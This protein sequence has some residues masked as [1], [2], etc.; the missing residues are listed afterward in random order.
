VDQP[1]TC[2][3]GLAEHSAVPAKFAELIDAL[4]E[5]LEL[6]T[7]SLDW[8]SPNTQGELVVYRKLAKEYREIANQLASTASYMSGCRDLP[9][10][11]HNQKALSDPSIIRAF[12][13]FTRT[14]EE[15]AALLRDRV[16]QDQLL[17][18]MMRGNTVKSR[19]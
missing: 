16:E 8:P 17:L 7:R 11:E 19:R 2:G 1:V 6:H 14:E 4:A 18:Q 10:G 9:M 5:N 12:E 15:L 3:K 13:T